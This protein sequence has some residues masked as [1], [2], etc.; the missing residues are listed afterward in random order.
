MPP[1]SE[2]I[3]KLWGAPGDTGSDPLGPSAPPAPPELADRDH[4][5]LPRIGLH[6][7]R[8]AHGRLRCLIDALNRLPSAPVLAAPDPESAA[9]AGSPVEQHA[10]TDDR[11][12]G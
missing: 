10:A 8:A 6:F 9:A 1:S 2:D 12:D 5:D 4:V 7:D 11:T 3:S